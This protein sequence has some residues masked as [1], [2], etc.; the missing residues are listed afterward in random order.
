[1]AIL[2]QRVDVAQEDIGKLMASQQLLSN[3]DLTLKNFNEVIENLKECEAFIEGVINGDHAGDSELGRLLDDCMGQ[4]ST[5]E[6]SLM[7]SLVASNFEDAMMLSSLSKLQQH[8]LRISSN[9]HS[10]FADSINTQ[11]HSTSSSSR[12]SKESR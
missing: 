2:Q 4:F 3:R 12:K 6:M 10:I 11:A 9:L 5:N 7:E 8:Q 1:M